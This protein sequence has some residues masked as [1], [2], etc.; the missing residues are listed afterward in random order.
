MCLQLSSNNDILVCSVG[1]HR[2]D[3]LSLGAQSS[4]K[5]KDILVGLV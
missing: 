4:L 5:L 1:A 2:L 3:L